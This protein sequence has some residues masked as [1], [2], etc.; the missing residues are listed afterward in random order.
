MISIS[1][2]AGLATNASP[3]SIPPGSSTLQVNL[4]CLSPGE[5]VCRKGLTV[6][7][8]DGSSPVVRCFLYY[9]NGTAT[10]VYQRENG[11]IDFQ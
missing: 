4:Q 8:V 10:I 7:P 3:Y 11:A 1:Q 9:N 6:S 2:W 5:L